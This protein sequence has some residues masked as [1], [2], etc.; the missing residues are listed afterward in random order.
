MKNNYLKERD[1]DHPYEVW[2]DGDKDW[3]W[4][5]L[6]KWQVNDDKPYA[7]WFVAVKS[8]MTYGSFE[9]G[10]TYVEEIK[11]VA[12]LV[13]EDQMISGLWKLTKYEEDTGEL[14]DVNPETGMC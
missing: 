8:P 2:V 10:D 12:T 13:W 14:S 4:R 6:K 1:V 9:Y 11:S 5:V 3:E 7:R